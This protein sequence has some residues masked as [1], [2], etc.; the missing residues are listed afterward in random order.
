MRKL[1]ERGSTHS[2]TLRIQKNIYQM[3]LWRKMEDKRRHCGAFARMSPS[4]SRLVGALLSNDLSFPLPSMYDLVG[5]V[6]CQRLSDA[7]LPG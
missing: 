7:G 4:L 2:L 1:T 5:V 6:H 3:A